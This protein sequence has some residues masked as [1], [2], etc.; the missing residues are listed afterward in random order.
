[1]F[2]SHIAAQRI[3]WKDTNGDMWGMGT[4]HTRSSVGLGI[5]TNEDV[6]M[7]PCRINALDN[8]HILA[9]GL[10]ILLALNKDNELWGMGHI[11]NTKIPKKLE[12]STKII[13]ISSGDGHCMAIDTDNNLWAIGRN[14]EA[15]L[16]LGDKKNREEWNTVSDIPKIK[17]VFCGAFFTILLDVEGNIWSFGS[18][19]LGALGLSMKE[20]VE[21]TKPNK[22]ENF[23]AVHS[24]SCGF[25]HSLVLDNDG[26]VWVFGS[27][28]YGQGGKLTSEANS[29]LSPV[30]IEI[31]N[32]KQISA[33][34]LNSVLLDKEG[35]LWVFGL[36]DKEIC[37][38]QKF[39][40]SNNASV[41]YAIAGDN[42][43]F[44]V[45]TKGEFWGFGDNY[46]G[47]L[48]TGDKEDKSSPVQITLP[49]S[50]DTELIKSNLNNGVFF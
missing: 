4:S 23:C 9:V 2:C 24:I 44:I 46:N 27:N 11:F 10:D 21:L 48:G 28:E 29:F 13:K 5:Q 41:Q 16:G 17:N 37:P 49:F 40:L 20:D 45:D 30:K 3:F 6:T 42:C 33:G 15:Q 22:L 25:Y 32:I 1:M 26:I 12:L 8:F 34:S 43:C 31:P 39:S 19:N 18:N 14:F 35:N 50:I 7:T 36:F 47:T 38:P